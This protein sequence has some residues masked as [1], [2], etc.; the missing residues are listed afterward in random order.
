VGSFLSSLSLS[1]QTGL[2]CSSSGAAGAG[3]G[4]RRLHFHFH[5]HRPF[6]AHGHSPCL[7]KACPVAILVARCRLILLVCSTP[8]VSVP[9]P[10]STSTLAVVYSRLQTRSDQ[11]RLPLYSLTKGPSSCYSNHLWPDQTEAYHPPRGIPRPLAASTNTP[12]RLPSREECAIAPRKRCA[13]VV[14]ADWTLAAQY[15]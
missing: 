11:L 1:L 12:G 9:R 10:H 3:A 8:V 5:S 6:P 15:A 14:A 2:L 7:A 4:A 13:R